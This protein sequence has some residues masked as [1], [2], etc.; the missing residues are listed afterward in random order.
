MSN[1][2]LTYNEV[3]RVISYFKSTMRRLEATKDYPEKEENKV[4]LDKLI[5]LA[6]YKSKGE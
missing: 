1:K 6:Y 5:D 4:I 3:M 2:E